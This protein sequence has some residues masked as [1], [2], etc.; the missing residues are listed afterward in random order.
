MRPLPIDDDRKFHL[1]LRDWMERMDVTAYRLAK[2][3]TF[4]VGE[5]PLRAWKAGEY[6]PSAE[7]SHR[8]LMT[9]IEERRA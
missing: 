5:A 7:K 9:L 3:R 6:V 4:G 2:D 8:A 1:V